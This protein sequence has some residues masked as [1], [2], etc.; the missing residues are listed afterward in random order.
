[1]PL[2]ESPSNMKNSLKK[3]KR[4]RAPHGPLGGRRYTARRT[5][6]AA[7]VLRFASRTARSAQGRLHLK[8]GFARQDRERLIE[9]LDL[10]LPLRLPLAVGHHLAF[11]LRLELVEIHENR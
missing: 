10:L 4:K 6:R 9:A 8:K 3:R 11:A 5:A 7:R 2:Q 1:M